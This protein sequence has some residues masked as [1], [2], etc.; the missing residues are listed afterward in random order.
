MLPCQSDDMRRYVTPTKRDRCC[1]TQEQAQ[2][3]AVRA[4]EVMW[5][6]YADKNGR[7]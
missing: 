1:N 2:E 6:S 3:A 5:E 4:E 7:Q